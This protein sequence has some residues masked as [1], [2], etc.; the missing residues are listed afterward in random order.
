MRVE[1]A[2]T[3]EWLPQWLKMQ[4]GGYT[5]IMRK[6]QQSS[7]YKDAWQWTLIANRAAEFLGVV[8]P[9]LNLKRPQADL[10]IRFQGYRQKK[11]NRLSDKQA[12]VDEAEKLMLGKMNKRGI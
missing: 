4:Y 6:Q 12:L 3:N 11:R 8:L 7:H 1:V 5:N 10:A 9:Y 2:N